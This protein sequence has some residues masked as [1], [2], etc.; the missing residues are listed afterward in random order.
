MQQYKTMYDDFG[1]DD[2]GVKHLIE[3]RNVSYKLWHRHCSLHLLVISS[4]QQRHCCRCLQE[5]RSPAD[6]LLVNDMLVRLLC[7][8]M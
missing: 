8:M 6:M 4:A 7:R 5:H 3:A 1:S 2:K